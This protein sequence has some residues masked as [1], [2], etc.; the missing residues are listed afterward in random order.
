MGDFGCFIW[1]NSP[2]PFLDAFAVR[3]RLLDPVFVMEVLARELPVAV[4]LL[5]LFTI[6]LRCYFLLP[7]FGY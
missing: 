4:F 3:P 5:F 7:F 6:V 1:P 2:D